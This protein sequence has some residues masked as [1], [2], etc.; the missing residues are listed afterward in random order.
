MKREDKFKARIVPVSNY[1]EIKKKID[2]SP[3]NGVESEGNPIFC[4]F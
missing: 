4:Q 2:P 1:G 3:I